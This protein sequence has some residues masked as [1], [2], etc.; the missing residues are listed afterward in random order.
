MEKYREGLFKLD[1]KRIALIDRE[2]YILQSVRDECIESG[3]GGLTTDMIYI[4][5]KALE[6]L[7][8]TGYVRIVQGLGTWL[9]L[10]MENG[11]IPTDGP[12]TSKLPPAY[13]DQLDDEIKAKLK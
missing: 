13:Y 1:F 12:R 6:Q 9:E 5:D 2:G 10:D 11:V 3:H 8:E 4:L 7:F